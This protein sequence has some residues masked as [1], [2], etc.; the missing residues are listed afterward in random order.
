MTASDFVFE[1]EYI[2][3]TDA[4]ERLAEAWEIIF[5]LILEDYENELRE[6][7]ILEVKE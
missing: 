4:E 2:P 1:Y 7:Q 3:S 6:A 5:L